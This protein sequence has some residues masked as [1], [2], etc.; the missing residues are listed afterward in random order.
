MA[1]I[2]IA[3]WNLQNLFDVTIS[4]IAA[5][6]GYTPGNGWTEEVMNQKIENLAAVINRMHDG[7]KPDLLGVCEI[8]NKNLA[9]K[10]I[11]KIGRDDYKVAHVDSPDIRELIL[12]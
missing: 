3:F 5:D 8:E 11:E 10:L 1:E 4:E 6:L 12:H 9:E 2:K 7:D